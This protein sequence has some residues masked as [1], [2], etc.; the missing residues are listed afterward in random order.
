MVPKWKVE[1]DSFA[2]PHFLIFFFVVFT[3]INVFLVDCENLQ[4]TCP[5]ATTETQTTFF[6]GLPCKKPTDI[7]AHD[8]KNQ[9]LTNAG[10][11]INIYRSSMKIV[12]A[13][14]FP[15]LNTLAISTGRTDIGVDGRVPLH[16]HPRAT[17]MI[18]V[19]KGV[20][21]AGFLDTQNQLF[22]T[23]LNV[24]D[25]FVI[26]KG[27]FHFCLN[28]GAE[29]ATFLSVFN[30]QSPGLGSVTSSPSETTIDSLHK[31]IPLSASQVHDI[32]NT[33]FT[34]PAL[35]SIFS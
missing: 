15:G 26:P 22:Q 31:L 5:T 1:M 21:L 33:N 7:A 8:F 4:D 20:V 10:S 30:S 34:F 11:T 23:F 3:S 35:D 27:L 17:E 32:T 18:Y 24:G 19:T 29:V 16:Y 13:V 12:T 28:R 6:N 25:V 9:D 14:E 2:P